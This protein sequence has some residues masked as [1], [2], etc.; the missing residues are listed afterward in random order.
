EDAEIIATVNRGLPLYN[1]NTYNVAPTFSKVVGEEALDDIKAVP[2]PYYAYN[3]Y[4]GGRL[5]N[6]VKIINL[7]VTCT[8]TIYTVNGTLVRTFKKDDPT[9]TSIDWDLKNSD[10]I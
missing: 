9:R 10:N 6:I 5:E 2:N 3:A 4:E 7:P 1:F 8:V